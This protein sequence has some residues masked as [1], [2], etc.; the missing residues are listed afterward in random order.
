[1]SELTVEDLVA[2]SDLETITYF[3]VSA[4]RS[5]SA[6]PAEDEDIA[7]VHTLH[8]AM[9]DDDKG[10]RIRVRTEID[11]SIGSIVVD[12]SADYELATLSARTIN[13]AVM[14]T[15]VNGVAVMTLIPYIRQSVSDITLKVFGS[16]LTMALV[17]RGE[18]DF[19]LTPAKASG[20]EE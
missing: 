20:A 2:D 13:Q 12:V 4:V 14:Q 6:T 8:T 18:M 3:E 5:S 1:M 19:D 9:R 7:P 10:F 17:R 11:V 16:A 15:F